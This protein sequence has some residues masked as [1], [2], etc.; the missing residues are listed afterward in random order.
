MEYILTV[1]EK[2]AHKWDNNEG[3]GDFVGAYDL[4]I[5]STPFKDLT[6]D[7]IINAVRNAITVDDELTF[8]DLYVDDESDIISFNQ[9]EDADRL[10]DSN[11]GYIVD[12]TCKIERF[13][14]VNLSKIAQ[15]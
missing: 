5:K 13:E 2:T 8:D 14:L 1:L 11:G 3:E 4:N 7:N 15:N 6:G 12:Y 9:I 10:P